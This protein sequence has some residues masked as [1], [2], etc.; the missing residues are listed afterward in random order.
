MSFVRTWELAGIART[1]K[2]K[3]SEIEGFIEV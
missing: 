1:R 3:T 2:A